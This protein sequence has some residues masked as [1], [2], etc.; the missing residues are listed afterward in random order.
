[1][2]EEYL[3]EI[4]IKRRE[5]NYYHTIDEFKG[6]DV[7][8]INHIIEKYGLKKSKIEKINENIRRCLYGK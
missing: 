5:Q 1:M 7:D 6:N 8:A 2:Q 3:F 4:K